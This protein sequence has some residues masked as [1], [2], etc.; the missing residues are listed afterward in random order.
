VRKS[1]K[2]RWVWRVARM[3]EVTV[4]YKISFKKKKVN[5]PFGTARHTWKFSVKTDVQDIRFE[6]MD[7]NQLTQNKVQWWT[8]VNMVMNFWFHK[9]LGIYWPGERM[10][11]LKN[12]SA[13]WIIIIIYIIIISFILKL[14]LTT[15]LLLTRFSPV[16]IQNLREIF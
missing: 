15:D 11:I 16:D 10:S 14:F 9:S 12:I 4:S 6:A 8:L 2:L 5:R 7:W 1:N 13:Q 3:E